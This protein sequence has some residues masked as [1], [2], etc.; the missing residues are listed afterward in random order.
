MPEGT[1]K[2]LSIDDEQSEEV[3]GG[4]NLSMSATVDQTAARAKER[5]IATEPP[6][7]L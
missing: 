2:D 5:V 3:A 7:N 1:E 6:A 4:V